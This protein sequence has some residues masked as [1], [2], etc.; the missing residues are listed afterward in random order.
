[1]ASIGTRQHQSVCESATPGC[2]QKLTLSRS[3]TASRLLRMP[4]DTEAAPGIPKN[5]APDERDPLALSLL[6][7]PSR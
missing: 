4:P 7:P 5:R 3:K 6:R 1:M 2:Q